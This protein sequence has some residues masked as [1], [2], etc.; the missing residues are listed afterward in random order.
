METGQEQT[1]PTFRG[2]PLDIREHAVTRFIERRI[3]RDGETDKLRRRGA[4]RLIQK[5]LERAEPD[6][7][8]PGEAA[9]RTIAN[10]FVPAEYWKADG[11]RFVLIEEDGGYVLVTVEQS[12]YGRERPVLHR[13]KRFFRRR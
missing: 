3:E 7:L 10:D 12:I 6:E 13:H 2:R 4:R 5:L 8:R 9:R 1:P 11:W